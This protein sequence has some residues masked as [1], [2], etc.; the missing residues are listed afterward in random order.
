M[1][2]SFTVRI[3]HQVDGTMPDVEV[4]AI[5]D[6]RTKTITMELPDGTRAE[7][8]VVTARAL[9]MILWEAVFGALQPTG[10]R[11][12]VERARADTRT[13]VLSTSDT[14]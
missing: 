7:L 12:R 1:V 11:L 6:H 3:P 10:P 4:C 13:A 8:D 2:E 9:Q 5:V 14:Q